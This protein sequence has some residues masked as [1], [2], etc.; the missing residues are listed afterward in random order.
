MTAASTGIV[1]VDTLAGV[2]DRRLVVQ[3]R[4][5]ASAELLFQA[6]TI[7]ERLSE[8]WG[9][10]GFTQP[11]YEI[12]VRTGGAMYFAM[13]GPDGLTYGMTGTVRH[14]IAPYSLVFT[15]EALTPDG[16]VALETETR[17]DFEPDA[18]AT[19]VTASHRVTAVHDSGKGYLAGMPAAWLEKLDRLAV[20]AE[21]QEPKGE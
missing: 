2:S 21:A 10:P 9:P 16:E 13:T 19:K 3:R 11:V 14:V 8:W 18:D 1:V 6:C 4:I 20:H 15:S 12:D 5:R 7:P 17:F